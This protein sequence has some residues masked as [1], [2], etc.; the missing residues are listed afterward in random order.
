M[1]VSIQRTGFH[2]TTDQI[3]ERLRHFGKIEGQL[4][5]LDTQVPGIVQDNLEVLMRLC[6]HIP[7]PLPAF[8]KKLHVRYSGQPIKCSNCLALGHIRKN[9]NSSNNNWLSFV[10]SLIDTGLYLVI[11]LVIGMILLKTQ[12]S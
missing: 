7:S 5:Y 1:L 10:K 11:C 12:R 8:S 6:K 3:L 9:C 2:L 4:K